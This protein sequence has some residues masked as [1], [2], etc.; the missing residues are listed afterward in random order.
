MNCTGEVTVEPGAGL[1][2]VTLAN[3]GAVRATRMKKTRQKHF[4]D[5]SLVERQAF[6]QPKLGLV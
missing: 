6:K 5:H 3:A 4:M 1:V 2:T